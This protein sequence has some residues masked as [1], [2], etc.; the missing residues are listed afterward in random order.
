MR[1]HIRKLK[2]MAPAR[3]GAKEMANAALLAHAL[4]DRASGRKRI[5][6]RYAK[7]YGAIEVK[8]KKLKRE[9]AK[10]LANNDISYPTV[11]GF[12]DITPEDLKRLC[13]ERLSIIRTTGKKAL[14]FNAANIAKAV[15]VYGERMRQVHLLTYLGGT[16]RSSELAAY[17]RAKLLRLE[18]AYDTRGVKRLRRYIVGMGHSLVE[19]DASESEDNGSG[20]DPSGPATCPAVNPVVP[21]VE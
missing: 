13:F 16:G 19:S 1:Q 15:D 4:A 10:A 8:I 3:F 14:S 7:I 12:V 9:E 11:T 6:E 21:A 2:K 18:A 17:G 5:R 20:D